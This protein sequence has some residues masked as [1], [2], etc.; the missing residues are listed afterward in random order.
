MRGNNPLLSLT[1]IIIPI[2]LGVVC[3]YTSLRALLII[4]SPKMIILNP[5]MCSILLIQSLKIIE[6]LSLAVLYVSLKLVILNS[7]LIYISIR[8]RM[9]LAMRLE[10]MLLIYCW[11][12]K[13][14]LQVLLSHNLGLIFGGS[15]ILMVMSIEGCSRRHIIW[16]ALTCICSRALTLK[17]SLK[18]LG[19]SI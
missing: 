15:F 2:Q 13:L 10:F 19:P 9:L 18:L 17:L 7:Q 6:V 11:I 16:M 4:C 1:L 5:R 3:C 14:G 8:H 12:M